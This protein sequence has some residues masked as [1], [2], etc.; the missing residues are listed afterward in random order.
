M[1]WPEIVVIVTSGRVCPTANELPPEAEFLQKPV[2]EEAVVGMIR[3]RLA[4]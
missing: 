1:R 4:K 3:E 2:R